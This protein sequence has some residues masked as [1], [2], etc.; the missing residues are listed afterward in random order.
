MNMKPIA[1]ILSLRMIAAVLLASSPVF[2]AKPKVAMSNPD[3]TKG[4]T[5][6]VEAK[7]DW[8]LGATGARG[9]MFTDHFSTTNAR[10]IAVRYPRQSR[11]L[12]IC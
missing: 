4:D 11:G 2:A 7:H 5:I 6:P 9:W 1:S 12:A 3:F 8:T 10:Q